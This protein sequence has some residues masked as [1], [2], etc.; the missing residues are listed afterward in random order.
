[1]SKE[2][3]PLKSQTNISKTSTKSNTNLYQFYI[4]NNELNREY[5]FKDNKVDTTKYNVITFLPKALM[6][7]FMRPANVYFLFCAIIQC[8]QQYL[9]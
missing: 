4:N 2:N 3:T 8:I 9:L 5:K 1:M 7:Q 6:Y